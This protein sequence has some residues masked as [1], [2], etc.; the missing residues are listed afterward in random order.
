M[1]LTQQDMDKIRERYP[2]TNFNNLA[3]CPSCGHESPLSSLTLKCDGA[4][5]LLAC[6]GPKE[7]CGHM[8]MEFQSSLPPSMF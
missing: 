3:L 1:A 6:Y 4:G 7:K 2:T 5:K 8:I